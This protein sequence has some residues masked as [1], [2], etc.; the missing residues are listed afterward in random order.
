VETIR[1]D[2]APEAVGAYSQGRRVGNRIIT[3]GQIGLDPITGDLCDDSSVAEFEQCLNNVLAVVKA[4]GGSPESIVQTRAFLKD[5]DEYDTLNSVYVERFEEPLPARTV[6]GVN[7][8]PGGAR[9]EI[10]A[11]AERS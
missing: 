9:V 4:G 5:L 2:E 6:V 7:D 1:T 8:L 10:E 11:T 3:S